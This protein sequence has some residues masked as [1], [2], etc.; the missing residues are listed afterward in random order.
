MRQSFCSLPTAKKEALLVAQRIQQGLQHVT[1]LTPADRD[2][3]VA[4]TKL[5]AE[6]GTGIPWSP[7]SRTT[8]VPAAS[9]E[10]NP[11]P[12]WPPTTRSISGR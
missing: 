12:A 2:A 4:A 8:C 1:D 5:L 6:S 3:Y 7:P 11:W 9:P 10:P